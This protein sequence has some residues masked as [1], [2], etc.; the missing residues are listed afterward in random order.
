MLSVD[1]SKV[2]EVAKGLP[3][4]TES[5]PYVP[6][7]AYILRLTFPV[8]EPYLAIYTFA[9]ESNPLPAVKLCPIAPPS[10]YSDVY[11]S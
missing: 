9:E 5:V 4:G 7:C 1:T 10:L 11:P 8:G 6:E 3:V 2:S